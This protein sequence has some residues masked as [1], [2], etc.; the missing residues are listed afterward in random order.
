MGYHMNDDKKKEFNPYR[1]YSSQKHLLP[2]AKSTSGETGQPLPL[3]T[4]RRIFKILAIGIGIGLVFLLFSQ[5]SS[6]VRLVSLTSSSSSYS[7]RPAANDATAAKPQRKHAH[8]GMAPERKAHIDAVVKALEIRERTEMFK[9]IF[10]QNAWGSPESVSGHGSSLAQTKNVRYLIGKF[11]ETFNVKTFIDSPCGD[12]NWQHMIDGFEDIDYLGLDIVP[13][14]IER[15]KKH[16]KSLGKKNMQ[17]AVVDFS[18]E[19]YPLKNADVILNR[20]MIQHNTLADGVRAYAN[21]EA[22][23]AKYLITTW[24]QHPTTDK[25]NDYWHNR[26]ISPGDW[27][28]VDIFL[29]PFN[30]S[31]P[32][33]WMADGNLGDMKAVGVFRLPALGMGDGTRMDVS[34]DEW[35]KANHEIMYSKQ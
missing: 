27:Y 21:M 15:N 13:P 7:K 22:S 12:V 28:P 10:E 3:R 20:D 29:H 8:H 4:N 19:P 34:D 26:N 2:I 31:R 14:L 24:H 5:Q 1:S 23:G 32:L 33:F 11:L 30:F 35:N 16:F 25:A 18:A 17:F 9:M 6:V